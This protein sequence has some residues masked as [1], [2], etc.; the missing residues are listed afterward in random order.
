MSRTT[1]Q[2]ID[3]FSARITTCCCDGVGFV[4]TNA[5][6]GHPLFGKAIPCVCRR[7]AIAKQRAERLRRKSGISD[8]QLAQWG[9]DQFDPRL[10]KPRQGQS[11]ADVVAKMREVKARCE[12]YAADPHGWI[13]LSGDTGT[14]KTHLAYGIAIERI[15][16]GAPVYAALVADMLDMLR[17]TFQK[18]LFD[19]WFADLREM[20]LVVLDDL[21]A[22]RETDWAVE[23]LFRLLDYRHANHLPMVVTTN[24]RLED[25]DL[26]A[27]VRSRLIDARNIRLTLPC[28]DFR[29]GRLA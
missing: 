14:G 21:G 25:G 4:R 28:G 15:H 26:D 24:A 5:P 6:L 10:C 19:E 20:P 2:W 7:D 1:E 11:K 22:Q 16:R 13:I 23:T 9:L 8:A 29:P 27:R 17:A 3:D 18:D 12:A